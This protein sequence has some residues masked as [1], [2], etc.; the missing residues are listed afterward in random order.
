[1][2]NLV[3]MFSGWF[4]IDTDSVKLIDTE[5]DECKTAAVWLKERGNI[6]GLILESFNDAHSD[7]SDGEFDQLDLSIED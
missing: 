6:D 3:C 2:P 5:T 4:E 7:S 1:M